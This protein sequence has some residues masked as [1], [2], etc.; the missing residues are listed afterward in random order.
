MNKPPPANVAQQNQF[1]ALDTDPPPHDEV[2]FGSFER[3]IRAQ[4]G[5][6]S[7]HHSP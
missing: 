5:P 6:S 4:A 7:S 2:I 1:T 3:K